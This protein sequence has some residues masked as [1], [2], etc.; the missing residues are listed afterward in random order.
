MVSGGI[1]GISNRA[2]KE[3]QERSSRRGPGSE[4]WLYDGDIAQVTIVP[5]GDPEDYRIQ[6]FSTYRATGMGRN[7]AYTYDAMAEG[8]SSSGQFKATEV[9]SGTQL[10][11]KFGVWL[12]VESVMR[13]PNNTKALAKNFGEDTVATW[14]TEQTPSGKAFLKQE[15]GNFQMWSQGFGRSKYL[16]NQ[17]VDIYDEDGSLNQHKVR[18]RRTGSGRDDTS[19]SIKATND[20]GSVP[21]EVDGQTAADLMR[22]VDF[23]LQKERSIAAAIEKR[24]AESRT[25]TLPTHS[26]ATV[27]SEDRTPWNVSSSDNS[28]FTTDA[29]VASP[30]ESLF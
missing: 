8:V 24:N 12:Y 6:D 20:E 23:F 25:T 1:A 30:E 26:P 13:N 9:D 19:Y 15:A 14:P 3:E 28:A 10:R 21:S 18:I 22:P 17:I 27:D 5:S 16:W 2:D 7:G 29:V 11:T 4:L